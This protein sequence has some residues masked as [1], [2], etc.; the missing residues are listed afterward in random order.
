VLSLLRVLLPYS[1]FLKNALRL[2]A[3]NFFQLTP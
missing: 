1:R 3:F 2:S